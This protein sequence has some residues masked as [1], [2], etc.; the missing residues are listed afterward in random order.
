MKKYNETEA[1]KVIKDLFNLMYGDS[2]RFVTLRNKFKKSVMD[3]KVKDGVITEI[4]FNPVGN[5]VINEELNVAI[6]SLRVYAC[7]SV[8]KMR[9]F[10][11]IIACKGIDVDAAKKS[12]TPKSIKVTKTK[13]GKTAKVV[14]DS[15][16][17]KEV[18][19]PKEVKKVKNKNEPVKKAAKGVKAFK[20]PKEKKE[21][22]ISPVKKEA[23]NIEVDMITKWIYSLE[24]KEVKTLIS[25]TI[26]A[27]SGDSKLNV[28]MN[29]WVSKTKT[30]LEA[31]IGMFTSAYTRKPK[32][33]KMQE[34]YNKFKEFLNSDA[35][36]APEAQKSPE[37]PEVTPTLDNLK[38]PEE[39]VDTPENTSSITYNTQMLVMPGLLS[40]KIIPLNDMVKVKGTTTHS[41]LLGIIYD[42][43]VPN[44]KEYMLHNDYMDLIIE[45]SGV[46]TGI[47]D[48][49][50]DELVAF[51]A[52]ILSDKIQGGSITATFMQNFIGYIIKAPGIGSLADRKSLLEVIKFGITEFLEKNNITVD[53][54]SEDTLQFY[55]D[56]TLKLTML[57]AYT[58]NRVIITTLYGMIAVDG[59]KQAMDK[60]LE[61]TLD[62]FV[63]V[64]YFKT[65]GLE[66]NTIF[67]IETSEVDSVDSE[68][69][70]EVKEEVAATTNE[71]APAEETQK[72]LPKQE[73]KYTITYTELSF[74]LNGTQITLQKSDEKYPAVLE[75]VMASDIE[76]LNKLIVTETSIKENIKNFLNDEN[77]SN[78]LADDFED[79]AKIKV[80]IVDKTLIC[81]GKKFG[82]KLS[83]EFIQY[84]SKNDQ[85]NIAQF[86]RFIYNCSLNPNSNSVNELYD[87]VIKNNLKV[88]PSGSILLYK[89]VRDNYF[90]A[91]TGKFDNSPGKTVWM[92]RAKV[93][94][95]RNQ[96]CSNGLHLCSFGYSKFSQRLLI[97]ELHPKNAVSIPTDYNQSKMRC[98]EYSVLLDVTEYYSAMCS[99]GDYLVKGSMFHHNSKILE[100]AIMKQ[101]PDIV[102][103]NS[104]N[105]FNG[106]KG[107]DIDFKDIDFTDTSKK[108]RVEFTDESDEE[109]CETQIPV[110]N[111]EEVNAP[112]EIRQI[113]A[114]TI[115]EEVEE[116]NIDPTLPEESEEQEPVQVPEE[117]VEVKMN[118]KIMIDFMLT[119]DTDVIRKAINHESFLNNAND[120]GLDSIILDIVIEKCKLSKPLTNLNSY[121]I[122]EIY[123][124]YRKMVNNETSTVDRSQHDI[125]TAKEVESSKEVEEKYNS[126][127]TKV[128]ETPKTQST[129]LFGKIK[130]FFGGK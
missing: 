128:V 94:A 46:V 125:A 40:K 111:Q 11:A 5:D 123:T 116:Q 130:K 61:V 81:N 84:A 63:N 56:N 10:E 106:K 53:A 89:W 44:A 51:E 33:S 45:F 23:I 49:N 52:S 121:E 13:E 101:Y 42:H 93:N 117:K 107:S 48:S 14:K 54:K 38:A 9:E 103:K 119:G 37:A 112:E 114:A 28:T 72:E 43:N 85:V 57:Q 2:K 124:N 74:V 22:T 78:L 41:E 115:P 26:N 69:A 95:D 79:T 27:F 31:A 86:K 17:P 73:I 55:M 59:N 64:D 32:N 6:E 25:N 4:T 62:Y 1:L 105:G 87:F 34:S 47:L 108:E 29:N 21:K 77:V 12:G 71:N 129:G 83:L 68:E 58:L 39:A 120:V 24:P 99:Q 60:I 91:H 110:E 8:K 76:T 15:S 67:V 127:K 70:K 7:R 3:F 97:C 113:E 30:D 19:E 98:C 16:L 122:I 88:T 118:D 36:V 92:D 90:D 102:R 66:D 126:D 109:I 35:V 65:V 75:A 20:E 96:T 100:L 50:P 18:K 80:D 82:G 104:F